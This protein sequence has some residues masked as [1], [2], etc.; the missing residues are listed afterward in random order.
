[1]IKTLKV[2]LWDEEVGRLM[3][4]GRRRTSYFVYNPSFVNK[5][6]NVSPLVAPIDGAVDLPVW[7]E[8]ARI[9]QRLPA[10]IADSLP[11]AWGNQLFDLWRQQQHLSAA[12]VTPLDK[13]SF[14]GRRGMGALE[15]EPEA[16]QDYHD[17]S[18]D[19][20]SLTSLAERI[21]N[22]REA[23][24]IRPDESLTMQSLMRVGTSAGGRQPKA[25]VAI[26]RETG[27]MRSGEIAGLD[28]YDYYLIKF[29]N[30][31]FCTAQLEMTYYELATAAGIEMMPSHLINVDGTTHFVTQRYDREGGCKLHTQTLAAIN[32]EVDSYE[33]LMDTCRRLRLNEADCDELFRRM[34]FNILANNTDDHVKNFSFVMDMAG[35]WRLS[36]A[37]DLTYIVDNG[38]YTPSVDHCMWIRAKLR[39]ITREDALAFARDNGVRRADEIIKQ[40]V[41]ALLQVRDVA[42]RWGVSPAWIGRIEDTIFGHL[43]SWGELD[44]NKVRAAINGHAVSSARIELTYKGNYHLIATIDGQERKYVIG[45]NRVE[46]GMIEQCGP[47]R[48]STEQLMALVEKFML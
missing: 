9:Y 6:L 25:I 18:I 32:P 34:V 29:G 38:G 15:F 12:E 7:G 14:I 43:R 21:F 33:Q 17:A 42:T 24:V 11:D 27:E 39:D 16:Q 30:E 35:K 48:V 22:E 1:M 45:K 26:D 19:L 5:G 8:E 28:N 2:K 20:T 31:E 37:Y 36:P 41:L 13:L 47:A 4:D 44:D 10:F 40:V 46:H 23:A 3:W